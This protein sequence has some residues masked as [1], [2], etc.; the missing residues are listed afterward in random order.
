VTEKHEK[1]PGE[2]N[3][4]LERILSL[5]VLLLLLLLLSGLLYIQKNYD[6]TSY[7]IVTE[8]K[9]GSKG[10]VVPVDLAELA[11]EGYEP[12]GEPKTWDQATLFEKINGKA[13]LYLEAGFQGLVTLR[14]VN[15]KKSSLWMEIYIYNQGDREKAFSVYSRQRRA[16]AEPIPG[17][18]R[19]YRTENSEYFARGGLYVEIVGSEE[20]PALVKAIHRLGENLRQNLGPAGDIRELELFPG[21]ALVK[22]SE[23]LYLASA[24]GYQE[25]RHIF[26]ASLETGRG[27]ITVFFSGSDDPSATKK[28]M[29]GYISFLEKEGAKQVK[30]GL[31]IPGLVI[32]DRDGYYEVLFPVKGRMSGVHTAESREEAEKGAKLLYRSIREGGTP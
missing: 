32:L 15:T 21:E 16:D 11:P 30:S 19:A 29:E 18:Q 22:G 1:I 23:K 9:E 14:Y 27:E 7:G 28:M 3:R 31:D 10:A 17:T 25:F 8:E 6:L 4:T 24:F 5:G 26:T 20:D 13:P 2:R 12:M